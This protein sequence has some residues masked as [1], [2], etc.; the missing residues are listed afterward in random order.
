M[1]VECVNLRSRLRAG[2]F[3][4]AENLVTLDWLWSGV[5]LK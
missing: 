4:E 2:E 5:S 3:D 1:T